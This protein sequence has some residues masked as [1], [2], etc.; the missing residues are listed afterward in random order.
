MGAETFGDDIRHV[1]GV[2]FDQVFSRQP[3]EP[4]CTGEDVGGM[5]ATGRTSALAAMAEMELLERTAYLVLYLAAQA[6][7]FDW[8]T[9]DFL[10]IVAD[11]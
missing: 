1:R 3:L 11:F 4:I 7:P 10:L 5:R 6:G 8:S 9:H 2:A